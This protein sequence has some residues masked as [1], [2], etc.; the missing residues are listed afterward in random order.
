MKKK[1]NNESKFFRDWTTQKLKA[2]AKGYY[3]MIYEAECYSCRDIIML[4]GFLE[5]LRKRGVEA[6]LTIQF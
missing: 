2:E 1:Y 4:D 5:E 3:Q 6:S